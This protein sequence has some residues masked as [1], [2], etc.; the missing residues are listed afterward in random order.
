MEALNSLDNMVVQLLKYM[1]QRERE[2]ERER[3][4]KFLT[5][6]VALTFHFRAFLVYQG[7]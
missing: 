6:T 3:E 5:L 2:R 4:T 1:S 7:N